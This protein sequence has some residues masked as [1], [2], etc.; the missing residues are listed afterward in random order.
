MR[1]FSRQANPSFVAFKQFSERA[2]NSSPGLRRLDCLKPVKAIEHEFYFSFVPEI[3]IESAW[4]QFLNVSY[5]SCVF[6]MGVR[7]SLVR[8]CFHRAKDNGIYC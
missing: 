2:L 1:E 5:D 7:D 4:R 6:S 8:S 3:E